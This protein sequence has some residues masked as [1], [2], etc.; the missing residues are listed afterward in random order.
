MSLYFPI[1]VFYDSTLISQKYLIASIL[2]LGFEL[3]SSIYF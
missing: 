3:P 1:T 2:K